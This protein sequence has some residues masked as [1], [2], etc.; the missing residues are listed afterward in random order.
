ML[1]WRGRRKILG[2]T[3]VSSGLRCLQQITMMSECAIVHMP[4]LC[5]CTIIKFWRHC[6]YVFVMQVCKSQHFIMIITPKLSYLSPTSLTVVCSPLSFPLQAK[7]TMKEESWN[8]HFFEYGRGMCMYRT[9]KTRELVQKGIPD[10]L[11]GE[12]WL[13]FSGDI[14]AKCAQ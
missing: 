3:E 14:L 6:D 13:L 2:A 1:H 7:E 8:I 5:I 10:S 4:P 12:L 11:R 9:A